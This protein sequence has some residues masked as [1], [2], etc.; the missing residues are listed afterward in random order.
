MAKLNK[1][2]IAQMCWPDRD[3]PI[4]AGTN[5]KNLLRQALQIL[6]KEYGSGLVPRGPL[7]WS[8][9][10]TPSDIEIIEVPLFLPNK[11][12]SEKINR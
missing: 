7:L 11:N 9:P 8:V 2:Y 12:I 6:Q 1:I 4:C 3:V 5:K 10:I